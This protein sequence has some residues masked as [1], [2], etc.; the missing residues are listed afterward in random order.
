MIVLE[1]SISQNGAEFVALVETEKKSQF[2]FFS[3]S[4]FSSL[5][6]ALMCGNS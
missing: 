5:L 1:N 6:A 2:L 4:S 3:S